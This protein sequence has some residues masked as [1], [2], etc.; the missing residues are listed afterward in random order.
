MAAPRLVGARQHW[1]VALRR[2]AP[3][4]EGARQS[5]CERASEGE[6]ATEGEREGER[7][8]DSGYVRNSNN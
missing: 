3:E 4:G 5:A 2:R 7:A 6:R 8:S 1:S